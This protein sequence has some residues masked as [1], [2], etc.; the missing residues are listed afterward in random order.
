MFENI[1]KPPD[2]LA[3]TELFVAQTFRVPQ[4]TTA[5]LDIMI[6]QNIAMVLFDVRERDEYDTSRIPDAMHLDPGISKEAFITACKQRCAGK[7]LVFYCSVGHRSSE[8]ISRLGE[9]CRLTG[10]TGCSNLR[11]GIFRWYNEG[12]TV[13]TDSGETDAIHEY[14]ALWSMMVRKRRPQD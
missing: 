2:P 14:N 13:V 1:F 5:D 12:R 11:G 3:L 10:A 9:C 7:K 4:I 6:Q 8:L